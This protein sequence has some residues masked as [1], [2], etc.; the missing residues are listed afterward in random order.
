M[1]FL[2]ISVI[3]YKLEISCLYIP[4]GHY[5]VYTLLLCS[6]D[7]YVNYRSENPPLMVLF[8]GRAFPELEK[9]IQ[10]KYI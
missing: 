2:T 3:V 4:K 5:L 9:A 7:E 1:L 6:P 8:Q 10:V